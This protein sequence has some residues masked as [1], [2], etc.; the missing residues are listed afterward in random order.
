MS[1]TSHKVLEAGAK[2]RALLK[3]AGIAAAA[4][5]APLVAMATSGQRL[6]TST[7]KGGAYPVI[8]CSLSG[9]QSFQNAQRTGQYKGGAFL[10][11]APG[12]H[13]CGGYSPGWWGQNPH[14]KAARWTGGLASLP[15]LP[16]TNALPGGSL[17]VSGVTATMWQVMSN[18]SFASHNDR[19]W[20]GAW[21]NARSNE[22]QYEF[23]A[24]D[25]FPFTSQQITSLYMEGNADALAFI[26]AYL[27]I[28][29]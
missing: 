12:T 6:V 15:D 26:K 8:V 23:N 22:V 19:H 9:W 20:L 29:A 3:G 18:A 2:R 21:L 24:N 10:S 25:N 13:T 4:G 5:G 1:E 28:H 11:G 27:E 16:Y 17:Q 14:K 7:G